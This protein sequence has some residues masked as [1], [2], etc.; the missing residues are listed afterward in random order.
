M[1]E[2]ITCAQNLGYEKFILQ[3]NGSGIYGELAAF[4]NDVE[5]LSISFSLLGAIA[6]THDLGT[7]NKGSFDRLL[8]AIS[9]VPKREFMTN[10]V[11]SEINVNE[12]GDI[13]ELVKPLKPKFMQFAIMHSKN[14][15]VGLKRSLDA[16]LQIAPILGVDLLRTEGIT[17]CLLKGYEACVSEN[18]FP[19]ELDLY[20]KNR[21]KIFRL[22]QLASDMRFKAKFCKDCICDSICHSVWIE[23]KDE[24][25]SLVKSGIN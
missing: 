17:P 23:T 12:L 1:I 3:T 4:L 19:K 10:T 24:F 9:L 21:G 5:N 16:I 22:N 15:Q 20:N 25:L 13:V 11:I 8:R 14:N 7:K 2:I 6:K 18:Y